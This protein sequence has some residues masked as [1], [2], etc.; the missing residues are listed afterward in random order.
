MP[1]S[2]KPVGDTVAKINGE[3]A[4]GEDL[5]FQRKWWMVERIVWILFLL[6]II[7]D[8]LG[9]FGREWLAKAHTIAPDKSL[10]IA[11]ES[12]ERFHAPSIL[13]IKA[14]PT[15]VQNG[16]L[17]LWVSQS[18]VKSLGKERVIPQPQSSAIGDQGI[19]YTFPASG[20]N[21]TW[22]SR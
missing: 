1:T 5:R 21:M 16:M 2:T 12:V 10:E 22:N 6:I 9:A 8:L 11:Y 7:A 3:V 19:L 17:Q 15:A 14:S 18:I 13:T 20:S 4:V